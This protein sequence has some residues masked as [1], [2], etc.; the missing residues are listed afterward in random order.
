MKRRRFDWICLTSWPGKSGDDLLNVSI[1]THTSSDS[2]EPAVRDTISSCFCPKFVASLDTTINSKKG[3]GPELDQ[4]QAKLH[5]HWL[6]VLLHLCGEACQIQFRQLAG[7][8][9]NLDHQVVKFEVEC[10]VQDP[11]WVLAFLEE[12]SQEHSWS[13]RNA[14]KKNVEVTCVGEPVCTT[15]SV[16]VFCS[17]VVLAGVGA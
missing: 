11:M 6:R 9:A 17:S 14:V 1:F 16:P 12:E 4:L 13:G 7:I 3:E 10:K 8:D 2:W 15:T 5:V